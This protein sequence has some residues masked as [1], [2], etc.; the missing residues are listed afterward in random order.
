MPQ[1]Q[2]HRPKVISYRRHRA[3]VGHMIKRLVSAI[4]VVT[5]L[6]SPGV[7]LAG[8]HV[9]SLDDVAKVSILSGWR[10]AS[11][12]HMTAIRIQL[13]PGWKTYWRA[14]GDA[15][16]PPRFAWNGSRNLDAVKFHW[17]TPTIFYQNGARSIGYAGEVIIPIELTPENAGS[18]MIKLRGEMELGVCEEICLPMNVRLRAD[19]TP[20]DA[21]DATIRA[22]LNNQPVAAS[23]AGVGP[24]TCDVEPIAD[25]LR[26]TARIEMPSI[27]SDEAAIVELADQ[28]VWV[29]EANT[30]RSGRNLTA[31]SEL[32]PPNAAPFLLSR[33]DIRITVLGDKKAVDIRGCAAG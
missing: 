25:G 10:T 24:V 7:A 30:S 14:P 5:A 2:G 11:G 26:L 17:P 29:S 20:G 12:T 13:A 6:F 23:G 18:D 1:S 15:G 21:P 22:S 32:V 19:L 27:G 4:A 3:Y 16:I 28:T 31:V 8:S 33:S 9:V